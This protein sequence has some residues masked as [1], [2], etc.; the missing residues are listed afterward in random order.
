MLKYSTQLCCIIDNH[1]LILLRFLLSAKIYSLLV[2]WWAARVLPMV[3]YWLIWVLILIA[4]LK[5]LVWKSAP[6]LCSGFGDFSVYQ[7]SL[8]KQQANLVSW[9]CRYASVF[10][11]SIQLVE[12]V[13]LSTIMLNLR[14]HVAP[15]G[16]DTAVALE[17][18]ILQLKDTVLCS[19][20][21]KSFICAGAAQDS[22]EVTLMWWNLSRPFPSLRD[23]S[24]NSI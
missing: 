7:E 14:L 16:E 1:W 6:F 17:S 21:T 19:S 2:G 4:F 9:P 13:P 24:V 11:C 20:S 3:P 15:Q 8:A 12:Q 22:Y 23:F 10:V 18:I 5:C